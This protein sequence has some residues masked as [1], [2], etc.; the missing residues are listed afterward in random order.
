MTI[1]VV[2]GIVAAVKRTGGSSGKITS[3]NRAPPQAPIGAYTLEQQS[4][5]TAISAKTKVFKHKKSGMSVLSIVPDDAT[6]DAVFGINF[7]TKLEDDSGIA[8]VVHKALQDGSQN[9][10]IKDPFN[11]LAR[12]SLQTHME[13]WV[14]KDRSAFVYASR[15]KVDFRNGVKVYL[16]GIFKP[17]L[18]ADDQ[19]WIF[20]QEAWRLVRVGGGKIALSGNAI[21][22]AKAAQMNPDSAH[23][24]YVY[25]TI[26][27]GHPYEYMQKGDFRDIVTLTRTKMKDYYSKYYHPSNGQALCFGPQDFVTECMNLLE[28]YLSEFDA[29]D[30]IRKSTEVG[31]VN[32]DS[33][34][35][36]KDSV[37]YASYQDSN[38]YRL[39]VS[40]VLNDQPIDARTK[41]AWF[42]I[43]DLLLGSSAALIPREIADSSLG[44]DA[45]GGLQS[46]L[47]QWVLTVGVAGVPTE[48]KVEMARIQLQKRIVNAAENG[49]DDE[50]MK[51]TLNKLEMRFRDQSADGVP[52]GVKVFKDVLTAWNYDDDPRKPLAYSE[53]FAELKKEIEEEGQ[54]FLLGLMTR[55]LVD[56]SHTL[57]TELYPSSKLLQLYNGQEQTWLESLNEKLS[58]EK[59]KQILAESD[60]LVDIQKQ[61]DSREVLESISYLTVKDLRALNFEVP[62]KVIRDLYDS[63]LTMLEHEIQH[64]NGIAYVDFSIDISNMDF[65]DVTLLPLFCQLLLKGGTQ[66]KSGT[67]I[68][69]QIDAATGGLTVAPLVDEIVDVGP[70]GGYLVPSAENMVTKI[71]VRSS[72]IAQSGC[73]PMF[74]LIKQILYDSDVRNK[75]AAIE[76]LKKMI[77]DMEDD[78]QI[79]PQK[80]T[81]Y[82]IQSQYGLPGFIGEQWKGVTQLLNL[83]RALVQARDDWTTLANRMIKMADAMRRGPRNGMALSL[84]GDKN[85]L[86]GIGSGLEVF[87]KEVLPIPTQSTPFPDF[88]TTTH[89]W[90]QKG[91]KRMTDEI[92]AEGTNEAFITPTRL[93]SVAKGGILFD[94]GEAIRGYHEVVLQYIGG[95]FL[96]NELHFG[97]GASNAKAVVDIDTGSVVYQ[98]TRDP[99]IATTLDIYDQGVNFVIRELDGQ[100]SL[101]PE[102]EGAIIGAIGALDGS[103]LQPSEIG[104]RA[105]V[106]YLR[107]E[108]KESRQK[109]REEILGATVSDMLS[110]TDRLGSWGK[111]SIAVITN[112]DQ[113][114]QA[115]NSGLELS[116]CDVTGLVC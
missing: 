17:R 107:Q 44:D 25:R 86:K 66:T 63:G 14:D 19:N 105:L 9:F 74:N 77:D 8:Y 24:D 58:V 114:D 108:T 54:G 64:S 31:W 16:D 10:P 23:E 2:V 101:P 80:Y 99:N 47:R 1:I 109:F 6:Q 33:I 3:G 20:R 72:C 51:G 7:R 70:D 89:P 106:Q 91:L 45:I 87:C 5:I 56:N 78:L 67:Q 90:Y 40:Y 55:S 22:E 68:Q 94:A 26:F 32:L 100:P 95:Y 57:K 69:H 52:R 37:A 4:T 53:T 29:N 41:M 82:R 85:S 75:D 46:H 81:T 35:S 49:F 38:D 50:A 60:E 11:Q 48:D 13:N 93:N 71:V 28:P 27:K 111:P 34:Q 115:V 110:M 104:Y 36:I 73:L 15:N 76:I 113:Y 98:S 39:A 18:M 42:I 96:Y 43:E 62:N 83:R 79:N 102:A 112:Q 59:G 84:T 21:N 116:T 97:Q 88:A 12:G 65:D 61:P 103:A 30:H 92:N